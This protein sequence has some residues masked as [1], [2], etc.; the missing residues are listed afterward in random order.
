MGPFPSTPMEAIWNLMEDRIKFTIQKIQTVRS[1]ELIEFSDMVYCDAELAV[2]IVTVFKLCEMLPIFS[3]ILSF[4][5]IFHP[6]S[7]RV[8]F[9][10]LL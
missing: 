9:F 1:N 2:K 10:Y 7:V 5:T 3:K 8:R 4:I 6:H